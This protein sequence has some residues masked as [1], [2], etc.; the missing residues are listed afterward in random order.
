MHVISRAA[1]KAAA[2]CHPS[3]G[4]WLEQ[5][6]RHAAKSRWESLQDVRLVYPS[7]DQVDR[8]LVFDARGN[9][10]R[11][12]VGVKYADEIQRGTLWV[13][14]FLTHAAYSK[15]QWKGEC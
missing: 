13:K 15:G 7:A 6:W 14:Q 2:A 10:F 1:I 11:L 3:A 5:W 4:G 9:R 12:I 8:C